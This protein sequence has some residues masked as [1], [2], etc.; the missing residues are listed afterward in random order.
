[1]TGLIAFLIIGLLAVIVVQI[2]KV[3]DLAAKIR[4][5]EE[6]AQQS[7]DRTAVWLVGF[8]VIF[9]ILGTGSMYYFKDVMLGYG[10][11]S[12]A[13]EHGSL[14]DGL[15][16]STLVVTFIVF[17]IT[18]ILL[19]WYSYKYRS[20]EGNKAQFIS[21]NNTIE[22]VWTVI[23]AIVLTFLV[24]K[25]LVAWN[26]IMPDLGPEDEYLEIEATGY[27]FAWELRHPGY[28]G[29]LGTKD[30]RLINPGSNSLGIDWS[31]DKSIDDI[32]IQ[33]EIVL[34]VDTTVRVRITSKDVLHNFYLPH[35]RVKMDAIPGLPT[36]FI[37]KPTTT[38]EE[39][40]QKLRDYPEW[41]EPYDESDPDLGPRWKN[42][43]YE[44]ACAEL[45]G[46]GHYSMRRI[47]KIVSREE[48][49]DWLAGQEST[50]MTTV[51]GKDSDP[52]KGQLLDIEI[53]E[54]AKELKSDFQNALSSESKD[55][56]TI[57]LKHVFYNTGSAAL[58]DL[59]KYELD[60]LTG[61]LKANPT[62][63]VELAGHTDSQGD[64][65]SNL[66]LSKNRAQNVM[67]YVLD[68]GLDAS[69]LI[70]TGYGETL[71]IGDNGTDA[72]REQ[73]RRTELRIV[74]Q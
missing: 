70:Y 74:S 54:R 6:V 24:V 37:F 50:Y 13:S 30:F 35:F 27:Q 2:G 9:L 1:M 44:L 63:K 11:H 49:N 42:F 55:D 3:S 22:L 69:R 56:K 34:P 32:I 47:L 18:H 39:Y 41:N 26:N 72:G 14:I 58:S 21:H 5:E 29:K 36:Y 52:R 65:S 46:K 57:L 68:K 15:F 12:S 61:I 53:K 25:G 59:S 43:N 19:F 71:P 23:P 45:C 66:E 64:E 28:D 60:N 31:D 8:M 33:N 51:R 4:G 17:F 40:R 73:N 48:Y 67:N 7:N 38:T 16:H 62:V 10:P 20:R